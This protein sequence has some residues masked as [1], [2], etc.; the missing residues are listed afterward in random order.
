MLPLALLCNLHVHVLQGLFLI[1]DRKLQG[2]ASV[3]SAIQEGV[4]D[5]R[6]R[7][8]QFLLHVAG[9]ILSLQQDGSLSLT[10]SNKAPGLT[11]LSPSHTQP[12]VVALLSAAYK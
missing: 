7:N 12:Q 10:P 9:K 2:V 11:D 4:E 1:N 3:F 8:R 5:V 6:P